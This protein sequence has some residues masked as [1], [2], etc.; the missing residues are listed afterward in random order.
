[1]NILYLIGNGFDLN[2]GAKTTTRDFY[3][4]LEN[5]SAEEDAEKT[6]ALIKRVVDD[7]KKDKQSWE[8]YELGLGHAS[9]LFDS[10]DEYKEALSSL[11][12]AFD[13]FIRKE[14][15]R[16]QELKFNKEVL[17]SFNDGIIN[18]QQDKMLTPDRQNFPLGITRYSEQTFNFVSFNYTTLLDKLIE[19]SVWITD[20]NKFLSSENVKIYTNSPLHIHGSL[21]NDDPLIIGIDNK[22]QIENVNFKENES[23]YDYLIKPKMNELIMEEN[24]DFFKSKINEASVISIYG[25]SIGDTDKTWWKE[26]G[27]W[28][29]IDTY[30][31][32]KLIL[33]VF[34]EPKRSSKI[35][36]AK[37]NNIVL[38]EK[39]SFLKAA[40]IDEK[41][42]DNLKDRIL[43]SFKSEAFKD[44]TINKNTTIKES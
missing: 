36:A 2:A 3:K 34:F 12:C 1:M 43:I 30:P 37:L 13:V 44:V 11:I 35:V 24:M 14:N 42:L 21:K 32:H 40:D 31:P 23:L 28:L 39:L 26:I 15:A 7:I 25:M 4:F 16:I 41:Y 9:N 29:S 17:A 5:Y 20:E 6:N 22:E 19:S 8:D 27:K 38:K 10:I 33:N 18:L